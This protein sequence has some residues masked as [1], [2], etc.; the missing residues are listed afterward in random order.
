[1]SLRFTEE[2]FMDYQ[3]RQRKL[4]EIGASHGLPGKDPKRKYRNQKVTVDGI[5]FDSKKEAAR[6][7]QLKMMERAGK[8]DGLERQKSFELAPA[9]I[10]DGRRKPPMKYLADFVYYENGE[11]IIEDCKSPVTRTEA[12]YRMKKHLMKSVHDIEITES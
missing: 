6:W 3:N 12:A 5:T 7:Q 10:L 2:Q 4:N 8:I 9:V 11:L 1:M